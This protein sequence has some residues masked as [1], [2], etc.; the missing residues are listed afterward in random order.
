MAFELLLF[1]RSWLLFVC[2]IGQK[3]Y[4]YVPG[5]FRTDFLFCMT[6]DAFLQ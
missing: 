4:G 5:F 6:A 3:M 1:R 2:D